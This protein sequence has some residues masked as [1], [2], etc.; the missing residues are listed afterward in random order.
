[1][2]ICL[3]TTGQPSTNP[4]LVKEADAFSEAGHE[5]D[6]VAAHWSDWA[7]DMDGGL[8]ASRQWRMSLVDWRRQRAPFLFQRSR[9][10]HWMARRAAEWRIGGRSLDAAAVARVGPELRKRAIAILADFYIAHSLGALPAAFSAAK[11]HSA[12]YCFDAEDFHSGQ[13]SGPQDARAAAFA[14][15]VERRYLPE[16][17]WI[18]A[19]SP[20]IGEAYRDLCGIALPNSI[21]NVF[22]LRDRPDAFNPGDSSQPVRLYWFSQTIGAN[23]GLEDVVTAV[24]LLNRCDVQLHLRGVWQ[25]GYETV[26]RRLAAESGVAQNL[27]VSHA[28]A[29]PDEMARLASTYDIGLALEP[30]ASINND[31]AISNKIFTY[32]LAGTAVVA[33]RTSGQSRLVGDLGA[34]ATWCEPGR[35]ASLAAALRPWLEQRDALVA[36]RK[37]AWHL[38]ETRFNWDLEKCKLLNVLEATQQRSALAGRSRLHSL[39]PGPPE[40]VGAE[41][42]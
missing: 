5:V 26:L 4:R 9:A 38:G 40:T 24:G 21:L 18:T 35:P 29:P 23:R 17:A 8:L 6:V 12:R 22:P 20:G 32:V 34:A 16:C 31:I 13:L 2:K 39:L 1:V 36:A 3:I 27:I 25:Q 15:A 19:A 41:G 42:K 37:T 7:S 10:R 14:R 28:P 33:S 11:R 30:I